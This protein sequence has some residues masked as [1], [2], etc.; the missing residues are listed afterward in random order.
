MRMLPEL[1]NKI[2]MYADDGHAKIVSNE[3]L[4]SDQT[5][6]DTLEGCDPF[7]CEIPAW[8]ENKSLMWDGN[9]CFIRIIP[10]W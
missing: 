1:M 9:C 3:V 10:A 4:I 8:V 5:W 6:L 2:H 7:Q